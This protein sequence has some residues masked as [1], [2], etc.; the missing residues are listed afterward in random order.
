MTPRQMLA[1]GRLYLNGGRV[2]TRQVVP[3][4]WIAASLEPRVESTREESRYY[5]YGWWIRDFAGFTAPYAWGYGGQF[6]VLVPDL[7]LVVVA[8]SSSTP[9]ADRR[10]HTR[11]L[12]DFLEDL[13]IA[14]AAAA[15]CAASGAES[16]ACGRAQ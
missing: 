9:G 5:G 14:H 11:R 10:T 12:Y 6:I 4:E 15:V 13:V 16:R 8:T 3:A 1:F 2:G 7:D